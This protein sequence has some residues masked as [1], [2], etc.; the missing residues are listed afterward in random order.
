M[1]SIYRKEMVR[2]GTA[3]CILAAAMVYAS[4][5]IGHSNNSVCN[6]FNVFERGK[7]QWFITT[8]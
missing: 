6:K 5:V 7:N 4:N 3:G 8:Q 2:K 1:K